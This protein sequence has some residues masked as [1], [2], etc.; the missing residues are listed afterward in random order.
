[1]KSFFKPLNQMLYCR[2]A[3]EMGGEN[4]FADTMI[5]V[6]MDAMDTLANLIKWIIFYV[7]YFPEVQR[8]VRESIA[9]VIDN[10]G[11]R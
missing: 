4:R 5:V 10:N 2:S 1:M 11:N 6:C 7:A 9:K 3:E 8:K